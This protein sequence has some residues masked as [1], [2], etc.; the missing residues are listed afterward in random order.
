MNKEEYMKEHK[1]EINK[2]IDE[3]NIEKDNLIDSVLLEKLEEF[4]KTSKS[5]PKL[6]ELKE[7]L[8][9]TA[10]KLRTDDDLY[11]DDDI[12]EID[13]L[14]S[15]KL[16]DKEI[17]YLPLLTPEE[18]IKLFNEYHKGDLEAKNK[19]IIS[20]LRL[21]E[22]QARR[23]VG[24]GLLLEDLAQEGSL[25]L[26][27]A[28]EKFDE[29]RGVKF[30]TYATFWIK[31]AITR[32]IA[33][34]GRTIRIPVMT[35]ETLYKLKRELNL[36]YM[37][38]GREPTDEELGEKIG[39]SPNRVREIKKLIDLPVSLESPIGEDEDDY[40]L[41]VLPG[42]Y[43]LEEEITQ[44]DLREVL[45]KAI[46]NA[47]LSKTQ[48]EMLRLRFGMDGGEPKKLEEISK[49]FNVSKEWVRRK[50]DEALKKIRQRE[51][52]SSSKSTGLKQFLR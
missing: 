32:A 14:S 31:Q 47:F 40:L 45:E 46:S 48:E 24:R 16:Y 7:V 36:F 15:G 38:N 17:Y 52:Y 27:T 22:K 18:E 39:I 37:L 13:R 20:N 28:V 35:F 50:V 49:E 2:L 21:V 33:N 41:D 43:S 9:D 23:Y 19:I 12:E 29:T 8:E 44:N 11:A 42:E 6:Q 34:K 5:A 25:G 1:D 26:L 4:I 30:G 3:I 10:N 51:N